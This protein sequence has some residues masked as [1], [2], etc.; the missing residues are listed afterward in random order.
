MYG[1]LTAYGCLE[2]KGGGVRFTLVDNGYLGTFHY[3][4]GKKTEI[5]YKHW[6]RMAHVCVLE[7][8]T[9]TQRYG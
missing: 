2:A 6:M 5:G 4:N 9:E 7:L 1:H 8:M 3:G